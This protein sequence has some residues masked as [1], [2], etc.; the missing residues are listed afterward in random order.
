MEAVV[1]LENNTQGL[2]LL[3]DKLT[4]RLGALGASNNR[5]TSSDRPI[6]ITLQIS[7]TRMGK[8]VIDSLNK[9]QQQQGI[10]RL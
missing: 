8:V 6:E 3:A 9:L 1:P 5:N 7:S 2:D 10:I 4:E